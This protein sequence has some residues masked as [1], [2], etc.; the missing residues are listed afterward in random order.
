[1]A[2]FYQVEIEL[3]SSLK[4]ERQLRLEAIDEQGK[5]RKD[6]QVFYPQELPPCSIDLE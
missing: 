3:P 1:M 2:H 5:K 6:V 4:R